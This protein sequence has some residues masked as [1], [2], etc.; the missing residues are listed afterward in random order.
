MEFI[1]I[2]AF[3]MLGIVIYALQSSGHE[4]RI[5]DKISSLGGEV[6]SFER[7]NIFTGLG[8]FM[9]V[10]KGRSVYK[11]DY[12]IGGDAKEGWVRFGGLFGPDWR[13]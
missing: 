9:V 7:R 5:R 11:I 6:I 10:G 12:R 1:I 13:L 2:I 4:R 3:V 8:P